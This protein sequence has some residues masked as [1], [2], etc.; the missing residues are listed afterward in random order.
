MAELPPPRLRFGRGRGC[1][2]C[3]ERE[4]ALPGPLPH[5]GDDFD[6]NA[7]DYDAIRTFMLEEIV[8]RFPERD[9]WTPAD[10]EVV[11]V[12]AVAAAL[13]RL[14]D[15]MDRVASEAY[16]ETARRPDSVRRLLSFVGYDPVAMARA[17]EQIEDP[18]PGA[19]DPGARDLERHWRRH[20]Q[21][22]EEARR[23][24]P[25]AVRT[26]RRMVTVDDHTVRLEEHP[27][28]LRARAWSE[29]SGS[30]SVVRIAAVC[31]DDRRLDEAF[32]LPD[33]VAEAVERFHR[34]RSL[35]VP[36][37]SEDVTPRRVVDPYLES[38]RMAGQETVLQDAEPV[39]I[40]LGV[41][42]L[43]APEYFR[44]EVRR[45]ALRALGNGPGGFFEAGRRRFGEDLYA[46]DVIEALLELP[47]V[48]NVCLTR[49]KRV[50]R[51]YPDRSA[52]GRIPLDEL[53]IAVLEN[54]PDRAER[55]F[56]LLS[57]NGGRR[58]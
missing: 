31:W 48:E 19:G 29:W 45:E 50:G 51:Q 38:Y 1:D 9:R 13:D 25:L 43:V 46:S 12:E 2:D 47:G 10:L 21:A 27:L 22:M 20:P 58:G 57:L 40:S 3:G 7:R 15:M 28:V 11:L 4:V 23:A 49:F 35:P 34:E 16:L 32:G 5:V 44:S 36:D 55:G 56:V 30:W 54:D 17:R 39:G 26:Q 37:L 14:S 53:E 42:L 6:W 24:G 52:R 33:D 41:T 8:A 18:G